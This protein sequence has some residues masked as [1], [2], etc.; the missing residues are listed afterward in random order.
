MR[1]DEDDEFEYVE[2]FAKRNEMVL[3]P[4]LDPYGLMVRNQTIEEVAKA[5]EKFEGAFGPDTV[6]SFATYVR[7]MKK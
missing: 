3:K 6:S 7:G 2:Q 1:T 5:I 4:E